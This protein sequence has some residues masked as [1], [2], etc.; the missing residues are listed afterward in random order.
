MFCS[1]LQPAEMAKAAMVLL[2]FVRLTHLLL[3]SVNL[4]AAC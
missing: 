3:L 2:Y 1:C 4:R